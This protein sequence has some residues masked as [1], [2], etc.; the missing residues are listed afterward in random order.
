MTVHI[1]PDAKNDHGQLVGLGDDD[2]TQYVLKSLVDAKGDLLVGSA[3]DLLGRLPGSATNGH[4]LTYDSA[5][6][7]GMKWAAAP[8][9][10]DISARAYH[11]TTQSI[12]NAT[13]TALA[14]N[15][16]EYDT[17]TIHDT[18]TNNSR[19]TFKTAGKY[20][21]WAEIEWAANGTGERF[22]AI[23][24]NGTTNVIF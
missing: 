5:E 15:S 23:K 4:V 14:M 6:A 12:P 9:A 17:D 19:L 24:K 3:N 2:H 11:N 21:V 18:A 1:F 10:T 13:D 22:V 7:L 8:G 16:E 20:L